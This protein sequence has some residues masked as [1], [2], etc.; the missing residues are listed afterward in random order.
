V[1]SDLAEHTGVDLR[2]RIVVEESACVSEFAGMGYPNGT[3]L[4]LAHTL[5]QTGPF[6][7]GHRS[8]AMDGLYYAGSFTTPGIGVPM[9]L[10]SGEHA[11]DAVREDATRA[12][13]TALGS[14]RSLR[15]D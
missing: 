2:G 10:I 7:P 14:L 11:A 15:S 13:G 6:R 8:T 1:L 4:G 9:C 12:D 5:R 3:A